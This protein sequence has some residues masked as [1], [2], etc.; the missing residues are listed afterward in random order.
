MKN[1]LKLD[2]HILNYNLGFANRN[3]NMPLNPALFAPK[4]MI[5]G[6]TLW[7]RCPYNAILLLSTP[8]YEWYLNTTKQN[9]SV[10]CGNYLS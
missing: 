1:K 6:F 8:T 7:Q 5:L 9:S 3:P 4:S 2:L 10:K